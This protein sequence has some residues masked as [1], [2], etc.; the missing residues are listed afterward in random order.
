MILVR[1]C[2]FLGLLFIIAAWPY[3]GSGQNGA[4]TGQWRA[5]SAEEGSTRYSSLDQVNK[6]NVK[7]LQ[8][9][10][11]WKFDNFGT[12]AE[13][14]TIAQP[15]VVEQLLGLDV[16]VG[17]GEL[18]AVHVHRAPQGRGG[19][20]Q[21]PAHAGLLAA[22]PEQLVPDVERRQAVGVQHHRQRRA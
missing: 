2:A 21:C 10:W 1:R 9:A 14:V 22:E 7:N 12:Q 11:T 13:T 20:E 19:V 18:L 4:T 6:E 17:G 15:G 16:P 3:A 8:V 5:Y